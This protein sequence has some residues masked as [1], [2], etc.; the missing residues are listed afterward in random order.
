MCVCVFNT[1]G[2]LLLLLVV[3][4]VVSHLR[5][6]SGGDEVPEPGILALDGRVLSVN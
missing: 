1:I 5:R 4:V 3:V 6:R 2:S